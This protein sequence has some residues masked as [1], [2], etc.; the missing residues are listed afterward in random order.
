MQQQISTTMGMEATTDLGMYLGMPTITSRV[1]KE[2]FGHFCDKIDRRLSGW[3]TKY[4]SLAGC[5]TLAKS[6]LTTMAHYSM[7]TAKLPRTICDNVDKKVCNFIRGSTEDRRSTHLIAWEN[8]QKPMEHGG[9][10]T[11]SAR[12]ANTAFLTKL[13]WR[14]L[15]EPDS[16]WSRVLRFKYCKGRCDIDMFEPKAGMPNVWSGIT[17]N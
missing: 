9:L 15:A 6:T 16:L 3:K 8:L 2:T 1:T 4:M 13:G 17:K 10:A 5:I 14:V 7:Q 12:Q 11:K